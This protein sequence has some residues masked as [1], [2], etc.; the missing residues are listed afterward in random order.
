M[1]KLNVAIADDNVRM[2]DIL[3]QMIEEDKDLTLVGK[4][5][6]GEEICS[7]IREKEPDV[8]VL[9][10]IMPK[11][12][13]LTVME[14][15]SHDS[16]V[17]KQPAFIV[18]SAVGQERITEDAFNLGAYYYMLKPFDKQVLLSRIKHIRRGNERKMREPVRQ[19]VREEPAPYGKRN[20]ETDVTNIIHEI[21][22]PAH[23]KGYQYLRD[24][25]I[26]S[27]NDMEMLNSITK[28]LY[29]TIAKK[30]QTT[31]S[32]VE[33]AIRHA[34][35]IVRSCRGDYDVVNHYIGFI[36]CANSPSLSMLTMKIREEALEVP[37]PKPEKK[38][39][40]VITGITEDRLLELMRQA[41]T[42]F[43]ADMIIRLK[44]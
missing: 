18:V 36:N 11:M 1:E 44:K 13:G 10:I 5:H 43:W 38:E 9:D 2:A 14:H 8:V 33:R 6:N 17:K 7:I 39:E 24:A 19:A 25:I 23:I 27:V 16:S 32:R 29:P 21:G 15:C 4:A 31:S 40:N 30:H 3:G 12:D 42:E 34:F 35:D 41:Y 26:L 22:V 28:V 20:L 37:E